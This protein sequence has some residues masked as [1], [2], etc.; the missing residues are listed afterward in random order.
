MRSIVI[1][2]SKENVKEAKRQILKIADVTAC[3]GCK[4]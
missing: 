3:V 2:G 1:T 4:P